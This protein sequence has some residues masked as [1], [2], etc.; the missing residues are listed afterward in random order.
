MTQSNP[1]AF[2]KLAP[3]LRALIFTPCLTF[4]L[5]VSI[6]GVGLKTY[7]DLPA[8]ALLGALCGDPKLYAEAL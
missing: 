3:E 1:C 5:E 2:N 4:E 7:Q 6:N 8:P